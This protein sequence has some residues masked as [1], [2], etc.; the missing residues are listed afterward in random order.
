M[1]FFLCFLLEL[2]STDIYTGKILDI[3][4]SPYASSLSNTFTSQVN[5]DSVLY[6]PAGIG[7]LTYSSLSIAHH[8]YIEDMK[9]QYVNVV[10]NSKYGNIASFYS[11]LKS[12]DITA[13]DENENIIGDISTSHSVYGLTY[14]KGFPYFNYAKGKIDPMLI[15]PRWSKIK[16]V[17]VY[18]PKVYRFSFGFTIKRLSEKLASYKRDIELMDVGLLL[19]LPGYVQIGTSLQNIGKKSKFY[20]QDEKIPVRFNFGLSKSFSTIKDIINFIIMIDYVSIENN[21]KYF[22]SAIDIDISKTFQ[23]RYGY[24]T[25][26]NTSFSKFVFGVGMTFD[27]F[28]S[29]E[30]I[31]KGLGMDYAYLHHKFLGSTHKLGFQMI[32]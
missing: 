3:F 5:P 22:N 24:S 31:I 13:Y 28:L 26:K 11:V 1:L 15:S 10:F 23:M 30:S 6:N 21:E 14:S 20:L 9:Q 16:P 25:Q 8:N 29:K 12:G 27:K 17:K 32:W 19:V 4:P 7:L 18:I 2:N